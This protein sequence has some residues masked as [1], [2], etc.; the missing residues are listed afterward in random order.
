MIHSVPQNVNQQLKNRMRM[1]V[2]ND[3]IKATFS[4]LG[5]SY[6]GLPDLNALPCNLASMLLE[7]AVQAAK[8]KKKLAPLLSYN[9]YEIQQWLPC[10]GIYKG[11]TSG[12]HVPVV[13]TEFLYWLHSVMGCHIK[14]EAKMT[15]F[16]SHVTFGHGRLSQ[17]W[18]A[19]D[20]SGNG[21]WRVSN[22]CAF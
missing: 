17:Q 1:T 5:M 16:F 11:M 15:L 4:S 10:Q 19:E 21:C 2:Y 9:T 12:T 6:W 13:T 8:I 7:N 3:R 22:K 18:K 14:V 20:K